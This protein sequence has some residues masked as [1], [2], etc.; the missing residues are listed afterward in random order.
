MI[1]LKTQEEI[2]IMGEGGRILAGIIRDLAKRVRPGIATNEL[3]RAAEALIF[4]SGGKPSFKGYDGFPAVLCVSVNDEIVH[5]LPSDRVLRAG[6][7]VSLDLGMEYRGYHSD[8]AITIAAGN[9]SP[10]AQKLI[11]VTYGALE[12]GLKEVKPG[13]TFGDV[14]SAVQQFIESHGFGVVQDLCG[15][16]IGKKLH[17]EPEVLNYGKKGEGP[18]IQEGMV[19]CLE[20]MVTAGSWQIKQAKDGYGFKTKD[21]SLSAHFEH[22]I[23]VTKSGFQILTK[24]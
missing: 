24:E 15:H 3:N 10:Q 9:I 12:A 7:I 11:Q 16:G 2:K 1:T 13:N 23:A 4:N 19:F 20:P 6:D 21:G 17:E 8:M 22:T 14:G 5:G 18:K